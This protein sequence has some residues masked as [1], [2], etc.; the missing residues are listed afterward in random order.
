MKIVENENEIILIDTPIF[1]WVVGSFF[2]V[3][4]A[5]CIIGLIV[6]AYLNPSIFFTFD[7]NNLAKTVSSI[8]WFGFILLLCLFPFALFFSMVL[9]SKIILEISATKKIVEIRRIGLLKKQIDKYYF[10]QISRFNIFTDP[11]TNYSQLFLILA[12]ESK[13]PLEIGKH[14]KNEVAKIAEKLNSI[15]LQ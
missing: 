10:P 15:V 8:L 9:V 14:E 12:N 11:K 1:F 7:S 4:S 6:F 13:I 5:A 3:L 2:S